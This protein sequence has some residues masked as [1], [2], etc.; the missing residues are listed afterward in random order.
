MPKLY[1]IPEA[2]AELA[3]HRTTVYR[4]CVDQSIGQRVGRTFVL[5]AGDLADLRKILP[6]PVGNPSFTPGNYF[7]GRRKRPKTRGK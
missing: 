1:T 2:A 6:R 7:G 5:T 4:T 3:V